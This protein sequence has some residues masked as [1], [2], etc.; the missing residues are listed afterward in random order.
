M[1]VKP[2]ETLGKTPLKTGNGEGCIKENALP[3]PFWC[4][5]RE[6]EGITRIYLYVLS[7]VSD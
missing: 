1:G 7:M 3:E 5:S 4:K 6:R 2:V